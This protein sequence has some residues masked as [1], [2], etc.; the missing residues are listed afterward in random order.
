MALAFANSGASLMSLRPFGANIDEWIERNDL[1]GWHL[2]ALSRFW[3]GPSCGFGLS[4]VFCEVSCL[5]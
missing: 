4:S 1:G 5:A 2:V 3:R